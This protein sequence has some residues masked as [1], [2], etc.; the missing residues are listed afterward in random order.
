MLAGILGLLSL[1]A[2][3]SGYQVSKKVPLPGTG[4]WDYL[5][6][7]ENARRLYVSHATQVVVLNADTLEV[8][9]TIPDLAGVHGI[10]LASE[11][12]RGYITCGQTDS[13][14]VFDLR[15][16]K[17]TAEVKVGKKPDAIV[18][19]PATKQV[20]AMNGDSDSSTA[21]NAAD[22]KVLEDSSTRW[23]SGVYGRGWQRKCF[24]QFGRQKRVAA[25]RCEIVASKRSLASGALRS[26]L[27]H[28]IRRG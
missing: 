7:D 22:N 15:T 10:A 23:W 9:G 16:L 1:G 28:G 4:G 14:A 21:I 20:F 24:R 2:S 11:F 19:D 3:P 12:G 17:K 13:V 8:V 25:D 26:S 5:T 6:V 18:Y 27:Q